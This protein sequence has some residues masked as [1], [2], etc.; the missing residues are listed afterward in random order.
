[1]TSAPTPSP[2]RPRVEPLTPDR[3][4]DLERLFSGRRVV[5]GCWCMFWRQ[6]GRENHTNW[7]EANRRALRARVDGDAPP[8]GLLAYL[9]DDP[10]GWVS[11]APLGEFG[12]I[13]R[14][15]ILRPPA[16]TGG[17]AGAW[18]V[19]CF[20]VAPE[21]R[22][23]GLVAVLLSAAADHARA[24]GAT[25]IQGYPLDVGSR[26]IHPDELFTG[27]LRTFTAAGFTEVVRRSEGRPVVQLEL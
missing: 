8:P 11:V 19:N 9:G 2:G 15:P 17:T 27:A 24:H 6:T 14:S 23:R 26:E 1:M 13:R 4:G 12:R 20:Y 16:G 22:G 21:G 18:S 5:D 10:V 3:F 25:A 7:G